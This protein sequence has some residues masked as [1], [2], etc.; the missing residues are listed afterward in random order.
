MSTADRI[1]NAIGTAA[2][3]VLV[4]AESGTL[5]LP[6]WAKM[7]LAIIVPAAFSTSAPMVKRSSLK[8]PKPDARGQIADGEEPK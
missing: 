2:S 8:T 1:L 7:A 4:A 3:G 5:P 6:W